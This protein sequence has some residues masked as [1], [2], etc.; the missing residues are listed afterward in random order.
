MRAIGWDHP[1]CVGPMRAAAEAWRART[2]VEIA[3]DFRPL[4]DFNDQPLQELAPHYD[5]LVIDHPAVPAAVAHDA[6]APLDELLPAA[7]VERLVADAI[8]P[9]G[10]SYRHRGATWALAVDAACHVGAWRP[11]AVEHPLATWPDV[12]DLAHR[13]PGRVAMPLLP[14]DA[15]CALLSVSATLGRPLAIGDGPAMEPLALLARLA[16][17]LHPISWTSSPPQLL[18]RMADEDIA[19]VPL[20]FGY[21][22]LASDDLRFAPA[23][24]APDGRRAGVLGG[25][26]IAISATSREP[27]LAAAF[28]AWVCEAQAQC[29]IVL[30]HGGQPAHRA[31]WSAP[32][33]TPRAADFL[34]ATRTTMEHAHVRPLHPAWPA[35]HR[36]A[37]AHLARALRAGEPPD[38]IADRLQRRLDAVRAVAC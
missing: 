8:G 38:A 26:G 1:R 18:A 6:L 33:A 24:A 29:G 11:A 36:D 17:L 34:N 19:C 23:P 2:G 25:A 4:A 22:G 28:A 5:L 13:I 12:L 14:A 3:W 10:R 27:R 21:L 20:T 9:S 7:R 35:L 15:M 31:A 30:A 32:T 37:G 16:P